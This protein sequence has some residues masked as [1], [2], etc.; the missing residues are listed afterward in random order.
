MSNQI[1]IKVLQTVLNVVGFFSPAK[2]TRGRRIL[3]LSGFSSA[4]VREGILDKDT[5]R[6]I[7]D[8]LG[9]ADNQS[10]CLGANLSEDMF[11]MK[12]LS[13]IL[14]PVKENVALEKRNYVTLT[15]AQDASKRICENT[16]EWLQYKDMQV[17]V[18]DVLCDNRM[19]H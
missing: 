6:T 7:E 10:K 14:I 8:E 18:L 15:E 16:P 1:V 3:F 19:A 2:R 12:Q 4:M 5:I 17:D 9:L 11:P 13:S